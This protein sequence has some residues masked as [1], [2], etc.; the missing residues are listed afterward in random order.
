MSPEDGIRRFLDNVDPKI[1]A[2]GED[3]YHSGQV[4]SVDWEGDHVT[5][6][7][8]GSE[9]EPYLVNLDFSEDGELEDWFCDCPYDWG[10]VCKHT[11]AV[12]L[13]I[14][15]EPSEKPSKR[16]QSPKI[17]ILPL[18]ESTKKEQFAQL[19][20]EH[21]QEDQ[22]FQNRVLSEL[23]DSGEQALAAVKALEE[24]SICSNTHRGYIDMRGC[25]HI[26]ADLDDIL[27]QARRR[28]R[29]RWYDQ[30]LDI[31]LFVLLTAIKLAGEA[32]SSSGSLSW[33]VDAAL[34]TVELAANGLV[35]ENSS[36][37]ES[38][39]KI[40]KVTENSAFDGWDHWR[41]DL[42]QRA[43]ILANS[44]NEKALFHFLDRLSNQIGEN[45]QDAPRYGYAEEDKITRYSI[46]RS[47]HGAEK[48][49]HI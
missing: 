32:D 47:A 20:L 35:Q 40:L 39:R 48:A 41:Y 12:L 46:I 27:D 16:V 17:D 49:E 15:A 45:F 22:R 28:I 37:E 4:E 11:V 24:A 38:V 10:P 26:C 31:T 9:E 34:E 6:E 3:Y 44:E 13:A 29:Q 23:G 21:C 2:R 5:A 18:L 19:I 30:A 1:L 14:Q 42:L 7:V 25:D 36:R 33:T 43:A 8:S